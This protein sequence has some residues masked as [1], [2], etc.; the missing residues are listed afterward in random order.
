M[1]FLYLGEKNRTA[2]KN[3]MLFQ[4]IESIHNK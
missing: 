2:L 4:Y 1:K 3:E